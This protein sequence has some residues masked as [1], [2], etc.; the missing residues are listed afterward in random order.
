MPG[1][2]APESTL[3][4][5]DDEPIVINSET[6]GTQLTIG[7]FVVTRKPMQSLLAV[8]IPVYIMSILICLSYIMPPEEKLLFLMRIQLGNIFV[9]LIIEEFVISGGAAGMPKF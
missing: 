7:R 3:S 6:P 4:P 9:I 5:S 1:G 8:V 2:S